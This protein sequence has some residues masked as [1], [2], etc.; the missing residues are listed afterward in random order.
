MSLNKLFFSKTF[1]SRKH[2]GTHLK[3]SEMLLIVCLCGRIREI[4]FGYDYYI[5]INRE[6]Q[7]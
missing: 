4:V 2:V 6:G 1:S 3:Y 7:D 5:C